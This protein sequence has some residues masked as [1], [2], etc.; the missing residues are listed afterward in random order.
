MTVTV[1]TMVIVV[2][3]VTLAALVTVVHMM[4][5]HLSIT[6]EKRSLLEVFRPC[7]MMTFLSERLPSPVTGTDR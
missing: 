7:Q 5:F 4:T 2:T 3:M 6:F 1:V